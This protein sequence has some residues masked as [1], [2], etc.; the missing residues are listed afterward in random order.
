MFLDPKI[1]TIASPDTNHS[2]A[3][4]ILITVIA[5]GYLTEGFLN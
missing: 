4:I 2:T 3:Y 5:I 1:L